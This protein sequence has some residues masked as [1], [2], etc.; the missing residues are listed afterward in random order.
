MVVHLVEREDVTTEQIAEASD[1]LRDELLASRQNEFYSS[2]MSEVQQRL[3][4]DIDYQA[5]EIAVGT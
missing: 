1:A 2:Y 5:L 3:S 4:I